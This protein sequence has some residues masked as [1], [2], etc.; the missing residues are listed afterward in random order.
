MSIERH[1][2]V[3]GGPTAAG[4]TDLA[5]A[6]AKRFDCEII[7]A[8]SRQ[9]YKELSIGTAKPSK[10]QL[11]AVR[12][13]FIDN[14]SIFDPFDIHRFEKE[15][16]EL[17]TEYFIEKPLAI[18]VGGSGLYLD[19]LIKGI[20][21]LPARDEKVRKSLEESLLDDG[22]GA[23]QEMLWKIDPESARSIDLQNPVRLIRTLEICKTSGVPASSLRS[24][25]VIERAF[26]SILV[27]VSPERETLYQRINARVDRM[28]E[29]GLLDEVRS[30]LQYKELQTLRTVG[31]TELFG[32]LDGQTDLQTA[33]DLI[34]QHSR[35]YA[36]RQLTWF[37]NKG[38]YEWFQ[39]DETDAVAKHIHE[40]IRNNRG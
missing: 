37:R 9:F 33:K 34:R 30:L 21:D 36:K 35:N 16:L 28:M 10:E 24:R 3:I 15:A 6:L 11:S 2:I 17:L 19:A 25:K 14:C 5:V 1:L 18:A 8:D 23:L 12:H 22:I 26:E 32:Y 40:I 39:P 7:S 20:D 13:H 27:A 4:K 38:N 29:Q 31:Y